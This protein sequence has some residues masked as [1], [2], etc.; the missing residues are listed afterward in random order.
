M[1]Q[2]TVRVAYIVKTFTRADFA[3]SA[4]LFFRY[5]KA[6]IGL[7]RTSNRDGFVRGI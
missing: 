4:V 6:Y 3:V 1:R 7:L 2:S 5:T